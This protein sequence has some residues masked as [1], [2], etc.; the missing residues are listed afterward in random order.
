MSD[1][2]DETGYCR[3]YAPRPMV[4][5]PRRADENDDDADYLQFPIWPWVTPLDWCG[6][7]ESA[8]QT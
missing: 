7:W 3:R 6:E 4:Y 5:R 8:D 2:P 1:A